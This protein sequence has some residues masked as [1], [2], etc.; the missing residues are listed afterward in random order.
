M[1]LSHLD[2]F[3]KTAGT[4]GRNDYPFV[5][6]RC[7]P[8]MPEAQRA[9]T[10]AYV[11]GIARQP[12][13]AL[14]ADLWV[15]MFRSV[16]FVSLTGQPA[17]VEPLQLYR[18]TTWGRRRGMSWTTDLD[19]AR[20]FADRTALY[21][22]DGHVFGAVVEPAGM[23]AS[24]DS[25]GEREIVIDPAYLPPIR[26]ANIIPANALRQRVEIDV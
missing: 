9:A 6:V 13:W 10:L 11:W 5:L 3:Y 12:A 8:T 21:G 20:W 4:C 15:A 24:I 23:L 19:L 22:F 1:N 26:R 14:G 25:R 16:G 7:W 17:P 18:G 2:H